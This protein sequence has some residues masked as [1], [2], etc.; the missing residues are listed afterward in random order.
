[1]MMVIPID[2]EKNKTQHITQEYGRQPSQR[3]KVRAVRRFEFQH[4]NGDKDGDHSI[5]EGFESSLAHV[6]KD[7][8]K[9]RVRTSLLTPNLKSPI[10]IYQFPQHRISFLTRAL[11]KTTILL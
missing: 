3:G 8:R 11:H 7:N 2:A 6:D 1:M 4:H 5:A 9:S 10:S